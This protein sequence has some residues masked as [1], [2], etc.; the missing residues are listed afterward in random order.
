MSTTGS[1]NSFIFG[2]FTCDHLLHRRSRFR[3]DLFRAVDC[4]LVKATLTRRLR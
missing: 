4:A 2:N 1:A 3:F